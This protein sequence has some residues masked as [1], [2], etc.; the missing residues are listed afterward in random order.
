[1]YSA[2]VGTTHDAMAR[3]KGQGVRMAYAPARNT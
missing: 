1:M 2:A 3:L